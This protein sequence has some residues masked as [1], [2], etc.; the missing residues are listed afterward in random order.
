MKLLVGL[1]KTDLL[2][3][4]YKMYIVDVDEIRAESF[5]KNNWEKLDI[6][7][8][9]ECQ[10]VQ[11]NVNN[12]KSYEQNP[13]EYLEASFDVNRLIGFERLKDDFQITNVYY[14]ENNIPQLYRTVNLNGFV[15]MHDI[16]E[17]KYR[18]YSSVLGQTIE[19]LPDFVRK[20]PL[21]KAY[22]WW[23]KKDEIGKTYGFYHF[24]SQFKVYEDT[25]VKLLYH[26]LIGV[27]GF[28]EGFHLVTKEE[29]ESDKLRHEYFL[30]NK[31]AN[32]KLTEAISTND[33]DDYDSYGFRRFD[34]YGVEREDPYPIERQISYYGTDMSMICSKSNFPELDW[35]QYPHSS[36]S[37]DED[38]F[39]IS[40]DYRNG[41]LDAY[42]K[43]EEAGCIQ[44]NWRLDEYSDLF[45]MTGNNVIPNELLCMSSRLQCEKENIRYGHVFVDTY[46]PWSAFD[47]DGWIRTMALLLST[48][49]YSPE[50]K[51]KISPIFDSY[52]DYYYKRLINLIENVGPLKAQET[53]KWTKEASKYIMDNISMVKPDGTIQK[54]NTSIIDQINEL[55]TFRRNN[56]DLPAW[57][58]IYSSKTIELLGGVELLNE[59]ISQKGEAESKEIICG[60]AEPIEQEQI[61]EY[62]RSGKTFISPEDI[63]QNEFDKE[64]SNI[65]YEFSGMKK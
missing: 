28:K 14:D 51:Q 11:V 36:G 15:S 42:N 49:Y 23:K 38:G 44:D 10:N 60:L 13:T 20:E 6:N 29:D 22:D 37:V 48:Q 46:G 58:Q 61:N 59:L 41:M 50:F 39:Y 18:K 45:G 19:E 5:S 52:K 2:E 64:E 4:N 12:F 27:R 62:R 32:I 65:N 53:M 43:I 54:S 57:L 55:F 30:F 8:L 24:S 17:L 25:P 35:S 7:K 40:I 21:S 16:S 1:S 63:I 26:Y 9:A 31:T 56:Y 33:I 3:E 34:G 47:T